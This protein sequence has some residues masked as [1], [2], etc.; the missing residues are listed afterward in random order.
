[1]VGDTRVADGAKEDGIKGGE[2]AETVRRD[3]R[4][5]GEVVLGVPGERLET[6][7]D[8]S[9]EAADGVEQPRHLPDDLWPDA[10]AR[11]ERNTLFKLSAHRA[12]PY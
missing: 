9:V 12:L 3:H 7:S 11:Q 5:G 4:A 8:R 6:E 2:P 10:V 1:M